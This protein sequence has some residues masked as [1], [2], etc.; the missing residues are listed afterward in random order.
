MRQ[1]QHI[2]LSTPGNNPARPKTIHGKRRAQHRLLRHARI[3]MEKQFAESFPPQGLDMLTHDSR[4]IFAYPNGFHD[5][6]AGR[7]AELLGS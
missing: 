7:H 3:Q 1:H 6:L 4:R 5:G 2:S